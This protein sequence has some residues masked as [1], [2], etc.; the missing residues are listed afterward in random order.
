[1]PQFGANLFQTEGVGFSERSK[2]E[3]GL[4]K[5]KLLFIPYCVLI[6]PVIVDAVRLA[7]KNKDGY[8]MNHFLYTEYTFLM[9]VWYVILKLIHYP[10]KMDKTYGKSQD[11]P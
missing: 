11:K 4:Q 3:T 8:F 5:R 7:I 1:M 9:I 2:K 6:V 10:V